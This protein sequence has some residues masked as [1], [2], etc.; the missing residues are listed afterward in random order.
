MNKKKSINLQ[1]FFDSLTRNAIDFLKKSVDELDKSPKYSVIHFCSAIELFFKARLLVEHWSLIVAKPENANL[2][3]F[4]A[5]DFHSAS[6]KET[7]KR[8]NN[9]SGEKIENKAE[10]YFESVRNHRNK[11]IHFFHEKYIVKPDNLTL[12]EVIP[13]QYAAWFYLH[14]LLINQWKA[15]FK[16]YSEE[17][18]KLNHLMQ[19]HKK[20]LRAKYEEMKSAICKDKKNGIQY[21]TC[22]FCSFDAAKVDDTYNPL[23]SCTCLICNMRSNFLVI[24]C[25]ECK[26]NIKVED[27][28]CGECQ[29]CGFV[30]DVDF[31]LQELSPGRYYKEEPLEAY[32]GNCEY[33]AAPSAI[34]FDNSYLCLNCLELL[35][36]P[37]H[38]GYCNELIAGHDL[39]NSWI[40]GCIMCDGSL[41]W[42]RD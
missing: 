19:R 28:G 32:C 21:E 39:E 29:K 26:T 38:C 23:F 20:Y 17:I 8:L 7:I 3:K 6:M 31:L 13:E 11:L 5:G 36:E 37:E 35:D 18:E 4:Q 34:P 16:D 24:A 15:I 1:I 22:Y 9:I 25:P 14:L 27:L 33:S 30:S 2:S 41:N 12:K 42:N 10:Q 40:Y